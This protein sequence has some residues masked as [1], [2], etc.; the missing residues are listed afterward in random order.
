MRILHIGL[1]SHYTENM[2]YQDNILPDLNAKAGH[3]VI[4]V[5]DTYKY[6]NGVLK[7]TTE[8]DKVLD[9]GVRLIRLRYDK[10][11]CDFVTKKIQKTHKLNTILEEFVPDTIM[12]HGV[13]GYELMDVSRY[14][15]NHPTVLFYIDSHEDFRNTAKSWISKMAYKYIHGIFVHRALDNVK[16]ILYLSDTA[17][18]YLI[19]MY[20]IKEE[21]LEFYPL[22][23]IV[24]SIDKQKECRDIVIDEFNFPDDAIICAHSGKLDILKNTRELLKAFRTVKNEKLRLMI[25]GSI[26]DENKDILKNLIDKDDRVVFLGWKTGNE[27]TKLLNAADLYIQPGTPSVTSQVALCCGCAEIVAPFAYVEMYENN[28]LYAE[29]TDEIRKAILKMVDNKENLKYYKEKAYELA[30]DRFDYNK[31]A[32]RYLR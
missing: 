5:T 25:F 1:V 22:G 29:K 13:C 9:N 7:E 4:F 32:V 30:C 18:E 26:P 16:K 21:L 19:T 20:H 15:E 31:L 17:R 6:D 28:V 10:I 27:V 2:M 24:T 3:E 14:V 8:E 11:V 23:G 12:Y